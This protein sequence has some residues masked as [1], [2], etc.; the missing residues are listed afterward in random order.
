[1]PVILAPN[2]LCHKR[3]LL[4]RILAQGSE[5][6]RRSYYRNDTLTQASHEIRRRHDQFLIL[7]NDRRLGK[8]KSPRQEAQATA[9]TQRAQDLKN[10]VYFN[11]INFDNAFLA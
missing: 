4:A 7:Q 2:F 1:M 5:V 10:Q 3:T 6:K 9:F 11:M 8:L